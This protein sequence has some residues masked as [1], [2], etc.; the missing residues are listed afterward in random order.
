MAST[1]WDQTLKLWVPETGHEMVTL[2]NSN[3]GLECVAFAPDGRQ[4]AS[5]GGNRIQLWLAASDQEVTTLTGH[6]NRVVRVSFD[7]SGDRIYSESVNEKLI[8]DM[9]TGELL[10]EAEWKPPVEPKPVSPDGS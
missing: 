8:W 7:P 3:V 2:N 1:N 4:L 5:A 10:P 6:M 9:A